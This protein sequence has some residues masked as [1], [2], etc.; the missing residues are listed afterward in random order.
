MHEVREQLLS[1]R[2]SPST[3]WILRSKLKSSSLT[4]SF[5]HSAVWAWSFWFPLPSGF[6]SCFRIVPLVGTV[7]TEHSPCL[8][9]SWCQV[10]SQSAPSNSY[11]STTLP[12]K[13]VYGWFRKPL[14]KH[15]KWRKNNPALAYFL[16]KLEY[17]FPCTFFFFFGSYSLDNILLLAKLKKK[18]D[19]FI[20][21][22]ILS[23][24]QSS[25]C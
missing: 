21:L 11:H 16:F 14:K 15:C 2:F 3:M 5:T 4:A 7:A 10:L 25:V 18:Y 12:T 22:V 19:T 23:E 24:I 9:C 8:F 20:T 6:A 1:G 13:A 17:V